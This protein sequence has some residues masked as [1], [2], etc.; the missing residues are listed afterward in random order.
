MCPSMVLPARNCKDFGRLELIRVPS[1]AAKITTEAFISM[2]N[3]PKDRLVYREAL[4]NSWF[5]EENID[6][7]YFLPLSFFTALYLAAASAKTA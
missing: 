5:W 6:S 1:P 3:K 2:L 7:S 4:A